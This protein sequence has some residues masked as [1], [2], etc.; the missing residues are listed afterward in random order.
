[1]EELMGGQQQSSQSFNDGDIIPGKVANKNDK[2]VYLD[3][4]YKA[5]AFVD[6]SEIKDWENIKIGDTL[7]VYLE[8][9]EDEE[10]TPVVSVQKAD[11]QKS[12]DNIVKNNAEGDLIHGIVRNKV[13]GGLIVDV[14]VEAFLP[15]SQ[16]DL[17]PVRNLDDYLNLEEDFKI[18]KINAERR[19]IVLSRREILES[20]RDKM[21]EKL[22]DELEPKQI[23]RG[24]V[25]NITDFGAFVDLDGMDGLLHITDMSWGRITHPSEIVQQGQEIEVMVLEVDRERKRVSLG[26]K[27]K[28][29]NPWDTVDVKYPKGSRVKG[30]VVNVMPYGAFIELEEGIEGLIHVSEMSWTKK[31]NRASDVLN[32]G[33]EVEAIVLDVNKDERKISLGLRQTQPNPWEVIKERFPKGTRI[34]GKVRNMTGYGAFVQIQDDIDGMIH[35][36]DMSW[37]RKINHPSELLQKGQEVEAIIVDVDAQNQRI[38]LSMRLLT[39]DP[40]QSIQSRYTVGDL[41]EGKITKLASFG[42]FVE[43]DGGIDGLIHISELSAD[44]V[45]KVRDVVQVGDMVKCRVKNI[46]TEEKRIGLSMKEAVEGA[47]PSAPAPHRENHAASVQSTGF[48]GVMD[49]AFKQAES[50]EEDKSAEASEAAEA[51]SEE[52]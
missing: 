28:D 44:H 17:G 37:I 7:D 5:E 18:L 9:I 40:W 47:A 15:G 22:L 25:K 19:N 33:D 35:V 4:G 6:R 50:A 38:S 51:S 42:A 10:N 1:M 2:G 12:W 13:K 36:S 11:L 16:V 26:L 39:D 23:R 3:I 41:V 34:K 27:Q 49:E 45:T 30:K 29:G 24:I 52:K 46:N 8:Q 43:L 48:G 20:K 31:I 14:G 21:R 32:E